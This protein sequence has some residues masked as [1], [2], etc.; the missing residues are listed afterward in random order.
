MAF[1]VAVLRETHQRR[2]IGVTTQEIRRIM[3]LQNKGYGYRKIAAE[4]GI[5]VNTVKSYCKRHPLQTEKEEIVVSTYCA[6]CGKVLAINHGAKG[7][8]FCDAKCRMA[9]WN[10]HRSEVQHKTYHTKICPSCGMEF[11]VYGKK[12]QRFC[13]R[14]CFGISRRKVVEE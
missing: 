11:S 7:K 12:D 13:S 3:A 8:R 6:Q 5:S 10:S 14:A 1:S 4:T 9:W 2:L